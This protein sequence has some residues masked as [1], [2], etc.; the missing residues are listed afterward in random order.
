[1][2]SRALE[3]VS[4]SAFTYEDVTYQIATRE[5][6]DF[7][8]PFC[9]IGAGNKDREICL[10]DP[11]STFLQ[12][13]F[14]AMDGIVMGKD[15]QDG[16]TLEKLTQL[17]TGLQNKCRSETLAPGSARAVQLSDFL[18]T[19]DDSQCVLETTDDGTLL[20]PV[21]PLS[22]FFDRHIPCCRHF[23]ALT[24]ATLANYESSL[25]EVE[26][27]HLYRTQFQQ[28]GHSVVVIRMEDDSLYVMDNLKRFELLETF[29][30]PREFTDGIRAA[31]SA[32]AITTDI[33]SQASTLPYVDVDNSLPDDLDEATP[34]LPSLPEEKNRLFRSQTVVK[35]DDSDG[36]VFRRS[37]TR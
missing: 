33:D 4:G 3:G 25:E 21:I 2:Q 23:G 22:E 13:V 19:Q 8:R 17:F 10:I 6:D 34:E 7:K 20:I 28:V 24:V 31:F 11:D 12:N 29:N 26:S 30:Y 27:I 5:L 16:N 32:P 15:F 36:R 37:L 14:N 35:K 1:M 18:N 9:S